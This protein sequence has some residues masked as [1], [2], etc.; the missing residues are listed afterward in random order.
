MKPKLFHAV[1]AA[2]IA[3]SCMAGTAAQAVCFQ[4]EV[5]TIEDFYY[6]K[7]PTSIP[8][9]WFKSIWDNTTGSDGFN[10]NNQIQF[11]IKDEQIDVSYYKLDVQKI[12]DKINDPTLILSSTIDLRITPKKGLNNSTNVDNSINPITGSGTINVLKYA[13]NTGATNTID[14]DANPTPLLP[15]S[16]VLASSH[17][18]S[19]N[20]VLDTPVTFSSVFANVAEFNS[21]I[22]DDHYVY[23]MFKGEND[24]NQIPFYINSYSNIT[25]DVAGQNEDVATLTANFCPVPEPTTML[26]S[27]G[28]LAGLVAR[29]SRKQA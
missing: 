13:G 26:L 11:T 15:T 10:P 29:R 3:V 19:L 1:L 24:S 2:G 20:F 5:P 14:V 25:D 12:I 8:P 4:V 27:L 6:H 18:D 28:G 23:L 22:V 16:G 21:A 17:F 9:V 7:S